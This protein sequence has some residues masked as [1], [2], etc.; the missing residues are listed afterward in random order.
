MSYLRAVSEALMQAVRPAFSRLPHF[1]A[2][3]ALFMLGSGASSGGSAARSG[4]AGAAS[5]A[6]ASAAAPPQARCSVEA[7]APRLEAPSIDRAAREPSRAN[8]KAWVEL[9]ARPELR[10]RA[11]GSEDTRRVADLLARELMRLGFE[12]PP[13]DGEMCRHFR[14]RD[15][16][17]QNVVAHFSRRAGGGGAKDSP[18]ERPM[19]IL[20]AHYDAQGVDKEGNIY[21][22]ADDNASGVAALL[23]IARLIKQDERRTA[24]DLVLIAFGAEERG[25]LGARAYVAQPTAP[26]DRAALM[27]NL[28]MVGRPLLDGISARRLLGNV[29]NTIGFLVS[30]RGG[31]AIDARVRAA[32]RGSGAR[33]IGLPESIME[34]TGFI[35]DSVIFR[36]HTP[37]LFFSTS[38][39]ADY[40]RPT[41]TPEKIDYAQMERAVRLVLEFIREPFPF[42]RA[43]E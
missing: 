4:E 10:G 29:D 28:D 6:G 12:G 41:D 42:S 1:L 18:A 33:V 43:G 27:I 26:L 24:S 40:H 17:D 8:L 31:E 2:G 23:E 5:A 30:A 37:T 11:A 38:I 36:D 15:V 35:S 13:G 14:I 16:A 39:H 25:A 7:P 3:T 21:P 9:L 32:A 22:G 19:M 34:M 20:G